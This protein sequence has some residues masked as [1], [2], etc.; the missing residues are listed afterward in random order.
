MN[1]VL[2]YSGGPDSY[3]THYWATLNKWAP[4]S[5]YF[6]LGH[7]YQRHEIRAVLETIPNTLIMTELCFLGKWEEKD[8]TIYA[9]NVFLL[10]MASRVLSG[11]G[12]IFLTTQRDEMDIPDR[13]PEFFTRMG[14]L[15]T[16]LSGNRV[17]VA[18][19]WV[20]H[21]KTDMV[22]WY[23]GHGGSPE[24]LLKTRSCY[25]TEEGN[26]GDCP[27]CFRRY[28]ALSLN[29][30]DEEYR[31]DPARS[32]TA[33]GYYKKALEGKYTAKRTER[34]IAVGQREGVL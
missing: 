3:M 20:N 7:R 9:R 2:L 17:T 30:I 10:V 13:T 31:E 26:C 34:I 23:L 14:E 12:I 16:S 19:P 29:G 28:I 11:D 27:A 22:W 4:R 18:T 21:D 24:T 25:S 1:T 15:I 5:I 32:A 8:A 33:M 6:R